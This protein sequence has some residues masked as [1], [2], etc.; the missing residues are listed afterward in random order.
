MSNHDDL[1]TYVLRVAAM[2][3]EIEEETEDVARRAVVYDFRQFI[4]KI[5]EHMAGLVEAYS[6][7]LGVL[8]LL[9]RKS[10]IHYESPDG[11][12]S[13]HGSIA[14]VHCTTVTMVKEILRSARD[15]QLPITGV[16]EP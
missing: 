12:I 16:R 7:S 5:A 10:F 1:A 8:D 13:Q 2:V 15:N 11:G 3:R 6:I 14:G 4:M 9:A